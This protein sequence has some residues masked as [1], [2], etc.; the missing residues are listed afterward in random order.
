VLVTQSY[1]ST[2]AAIQKMPDTGKGALM[3]TKTGSSITNIHP[4]RRG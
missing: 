3:C 2:V 1:A 4:T